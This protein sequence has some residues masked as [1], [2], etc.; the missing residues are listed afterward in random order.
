MALFIFCT[1]FDKARKDIKIFLSRGRRQS[2][3]EL[4]PLSGTVM[5]S[6]AEKISFP[7]PEIIF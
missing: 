6:N 3:N 4:P 1:V 7:A 5:K 2:N